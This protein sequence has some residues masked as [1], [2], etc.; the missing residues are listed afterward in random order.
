MARFYLPTENAELSPDISRAFSY[1]AVNQ[2]R[3]PGR[4]DLRSG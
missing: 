1:V 3:K 4:R 2:K